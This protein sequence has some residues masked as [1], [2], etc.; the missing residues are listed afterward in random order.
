MSITDESSGLFSRKYFDETIKREFMRAGRG[1]FIIALLLI[2]LTNVDNIKT[3]AS[4]SETQEAI[5]RFSS[6]LLEQKRTEDTVC[7]FS[8]DHFILVS[9]GGDFSDHSR[10]FSDLLDRYQRSPVKVNDQHLEIS[11]SAGYFP[12]H[13]ENAQDMLE[14]LQKAL[15][16]LQDENR[17]TYLK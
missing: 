13:G 5:K 7:R 6:Y 3:W 14:S 9:Y 12:K 1:K 2:K 11:A 4:R 17:I 10:R 8:P 15:D 16:N